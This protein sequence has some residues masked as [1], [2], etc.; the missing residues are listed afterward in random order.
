MVWFN[1]PIP[2]ISEFRIITKVSVEFCRFFVSERRIIM[3]PIFCQVMRIKAVNH[4]T[5]DI[6][7]GNHQWQGANPSF[8]SR[9][10]ISRVVIAKELIIDSL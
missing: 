1:P 9:A 3:G 2:P 7:F 4:L 6:I 8:M 10:A 5:S